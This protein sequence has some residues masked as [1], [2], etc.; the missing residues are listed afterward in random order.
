M[1]S[2]A[3]ELD[4]SWNLER[5]QGMENLFTFKTIHAYAAGILIGIFSSNEDASPFSFNLAYVQ[6][7]SLLEEITAISPRER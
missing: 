4:S 1:P 7:Q 3:V 5:I 2:S 6:L